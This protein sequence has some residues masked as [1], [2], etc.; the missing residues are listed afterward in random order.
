MQLKKFQNLFRGFGIFSEIVRMTLFWTYCIALY[1]QCS[2]FRVSVEKN[3]TGDSGGI[4]QPINCRYC[5]FGY[6]STIISLSDS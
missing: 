6:S 4:N 1:T 3:F 2:A 5:L